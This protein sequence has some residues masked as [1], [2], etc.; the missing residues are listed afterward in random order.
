MVS[1]K[2]A[3]ECTAV[4]VQRHL[5]PSES[6]TRPATFI[7]SARVL[8]SFSGSSLLAT[9][10]SLSYHL[11][12]GGACE[13]IELSTSTSAMHTI[14]I[15]FRHGYSYQNFRSMEPLKAS[16]ASLACCMGLDCC[17]PCEGESST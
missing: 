13:R 8:V 15:Y 2:S 9:Y 11:E 4:M 14:D 3:G 1:S 5:S 7:W 10:L 16:L 6:L 17:L 12:G